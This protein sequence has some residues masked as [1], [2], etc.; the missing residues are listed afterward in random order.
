MT[1]CEQ[2]Q[3]FSISCGFNDCFSFVLHQ[4]SPLAVKAGD[5]TLITASY[6]FG[7]SAV[8]RLCSP[9]YEGSGVGD[10]GIGMWIQRECNREPCHLTYWVQLWQGGLIVTE[11]W[12]GR[13]QVHCQLRH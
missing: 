9:Y 4:I 2:Y 11:R 8:V 3:P 1:A 12:A 7:G 13:C 10:K 6:T 5:G